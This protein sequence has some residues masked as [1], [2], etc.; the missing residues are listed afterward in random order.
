MAGVDWPLVGREVVRQFCESL[1][2]ENRLTHHVFKPLI[3]FTSDKTAHA[4]WP[5]EDYA[6][7]PEGAPVRY[8]HGLGHYRCDCEQLDDGRWYIKQL[9]LTRLHVEMR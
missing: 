9:D 2:A 4:V 7:F 5:M 3:D 6:W 8:M 1:S